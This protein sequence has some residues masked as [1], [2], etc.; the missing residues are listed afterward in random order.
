M[1]TLT[2]QDLEQFER[3]EQGRVAALNAAVSAAAQKASERAQEAAAVALAQAA[4]EYQKEVSGAV[5]EGSKSAGK[6]RRERQ[7]AANFGKNSA[8]GHRAGSEGYDMDQF[9]L[10]FITAKKMWPNAEAL[11][12]FAPELVEFPLARVRGHLAHI[13][14]EHKGSIPADVRPE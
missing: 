12:K 8:L 13:V 9:I 14:K 10:Q 3:L 7:R 6:A 5:V 2:K 11:V 4:A 1:A